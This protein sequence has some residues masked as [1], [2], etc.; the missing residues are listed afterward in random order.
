VDIQ[1]FAYR[2]IAD[3]DHHAS[4]QRHAHIHPISNDENPAAHIDSDCSSREQQIKA[5]PGRD[6]RDQKARIVAPLM[7]HRANRQRSE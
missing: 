3:G 4:K 6:D 7:H 1:L 5:K 2:E